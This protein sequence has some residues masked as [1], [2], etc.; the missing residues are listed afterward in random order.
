VGNGGRAEIDYGVVVAGETTRGT[1]WTT[2]GR[3]PIPPIPADVTQIDVLLVPDP[4]AVERQI[5]IEEIWGQPYRI[6]NVPL[7]RFDLADGAQG[8]RSATQ[9]G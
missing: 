8:K 4:T 9:P 7:Q 2:S 3:K 5:D 6:D 1:T